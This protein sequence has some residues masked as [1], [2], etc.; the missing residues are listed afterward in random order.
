[1]ENRYHVLYAED[2]FFLRKIIQHTLIN[3][4]ELFGCTNGVEAMDWLEKGNQTNLILTDLRMPLMDGEEFIR[5]VR[6]SSL[7][8]HIPIIVLSSSE[9]SSLKVS[10]LE[11][12]A[13]DFMIKP[14]N[15][16]E[17][18]AKIKAIMRRV[19]ERRN[20]RASFDSTRL[21]PLR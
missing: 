3:E 19:T 8:D 11:I 2:D 16:L 5:L 7:Y 20:F 13:D 6:S 10:C 12:G 21:N 15:P 4:F 17:L 1:M 14:F 18:K 9:E